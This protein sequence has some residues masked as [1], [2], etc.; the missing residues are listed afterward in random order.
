M[1][2][3]LSI[4]P[5]HPVAPSSAGAGGPENLFANLRRE[6]VKTWPNN[7]AITIVFHGHS[8]PA[9]YHKTP[10]VRTF[11][12]YPH[13]VHRTLK[14]KFPHAVVN[15]LVTA[16]GGEESPKGASRFENDVL[17]RRPDLIFIDYG[18]NDRTVSEQITQAA[19]T[20]M[21]GA[22]QARSVPVILITPTGAADV[23]YN[24]PDDKLARRA[25][26]IRAVGMETGT[27]VAD[28]Q[29]RWAEFVRDGGD[30]EALL[31]QINHPNL[32]G[33]QLAADVICGVLMN[34][35]GAD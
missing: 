5:Q 32:A 7:R 29:K 12:S 20:S 24:D 19:W 13:L 18:L 4:A 22:A 10:E 23:D 34:E 14:G 26:I 27:P 1:K 17:A 9:G 2:P 11:E 3:S 30:Q 8:V 31:S 28:V 21:L 6:L 25:E 15:V 35:L 16:I 33:H